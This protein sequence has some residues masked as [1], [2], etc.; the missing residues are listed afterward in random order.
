MYSYH[1]IAMTSIIIVDCI[2]HFEGAQNFEVS[3]MLIM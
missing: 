2:L 1:V 3:R